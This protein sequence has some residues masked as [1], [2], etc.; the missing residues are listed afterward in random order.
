MGLWTKFDFMSLVFTPLRRFQRA[1][2]EFFELLSF[3]FI[4]W[5]EEPTKLIALAALSVAA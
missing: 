4:F 5:R 1:I 2:S 3:P